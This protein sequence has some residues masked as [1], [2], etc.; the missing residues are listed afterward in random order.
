MSGG[1]LLIAEAGDRVVGTLR[2]NF[3]RETDL[4]YY[5]E[6]FGLDFVG[7]DFSGA[8]SLTT[9]MMVHPA[10]RT[11]TL[12]VRMAQALYEHGIARGIRWDFIDCNAHLEDFFT[13]LGYEVYR[14]HVEHSEFGPVLPMR[15]NLL[16]LRRL[17]RIHS[18]LAL[19]EVW[20][21]AQPRLLAAA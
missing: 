8:V 1:D 20:K 13:R 12:A 19:C 6:L 15:L 10:Y 3:A 7:A 16:N 4:G 18:P 9:K 14:P 11:G 2:T 21:Q 17:L 5:R